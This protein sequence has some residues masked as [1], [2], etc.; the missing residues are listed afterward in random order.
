M[1]QIKR[2]LISCTD[3]T[4]I[5]ELAKFLVEQNIEILSTGGTAKILQDNNIPVTEVSDYTQ[6][7]EILDGRLKTLHPKI[8]GGILAI[9]QNKN[10]QKQMAENNINPIDLIIVNLYEFEKTISKENCQLDDAIENI[11]IGGPT[12][13]RSAAKNYK[14]VAVVVDPSDYDELKKQIQQGELTIPFK[15]K[16]ATKVFQKT[17]NYDT[18]IIRYLQSKLPSTDA[19]NSKFNPNLQ[20]NLTKVQ[21]LRYG[22][23][24]HQKAALYKDESVSTGIVN[25][26]QLQGKELSFNNILDLESA[27]NC[28]KEFK[29]P[30]CVIVKH[31]N[32]CGVAIA[33]N[34]NEAFIRARAGDPVSCFG[35]IVAINQPVNK[36][37]ALLIAETF[38]EAII[39]PAFEPEALD[40]FA[41][42]KNLR[43]MTL[44]NFSA[45][46]DSLD[47]RRVGGGLLIQDFDNQII[48]MSEAKV[49]T[50]RQPTKQE[51]IDLDFAWHVVKHVKSNAIVLTKESQSIGVGAG[52]MS[53]VDSVKLAGLK[54]K[55]YFKD[56]QT[57]KN[58]AMGSDAFFP[59]RDGIDQAAQF[60]VTAIVQPGGSMRDN[61][62]IEACDEH[63]ITMLCTGMRH[64]RH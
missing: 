4:G 7:P 43:L 5:P 38:F 44:N 16:L 28:C 48:P 22:E 59:F 31:L 11:D 45:N 25:A 14:D 47:Y 60:G 36:Q 27:Y 50:K 15:F 52:Q 24:P 10:H 34:S 53:R 6:S 37:T 32:P 42:K 40:I 23:N 3:K 58:V 26:N 30:A 12:M 20:L 8:H 19:T 17:A 55:E 33:E 29:Q 57:F 1:T 18:A 61:E 49:V 63:G 46:E 13:L 51:L 9:R 21:D 39:A 56:P 41:K 35:G 54:A 64:F 62:V 2:A